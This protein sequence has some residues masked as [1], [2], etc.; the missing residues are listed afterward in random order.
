MTTTVYVNFHYI[1][2]ENGKN[3]FTSVDDGNGNSN[4]TGRTIAEQ[5]ISDANYTLG[6]L[7][8]NI[9]HK[10]NSDANGFVPD[11]KYRIELYY[12]ESDQDQGVHYISNQTLYNKER[13]STDVMPGALKNTFSIYGNK[14]I[15]IFMF[16]HAPNTNCNVWGE[17]NNIDALNLWCL[18]YYYINNNQVQNDYYKILN[19]EI[20]HTIGL[21]QEANS[22]NC[23]AYDIDKDEEASIGNN[24]MR[25]NDGDKSALTPKQFNLIQNLLGTREFTNSDVNCNTNSSPIIIPTGQEIVWDFPSRIN[26]E[27]IIEPLATLII[28]C[29][30]FTNSRILVQRSGKLIVEGATISSLCP[31]YSFWPGI[32]VEGSPKQHSQV[33]VNSQLTNTDPGVVLLNNAVIDNAVVGVTTKSDEHPWERDYWGGII[34]ASTTTFSNNRKGVE[35]YPYRNENAS[36]FYECEFSSSK[37]YA[38]ISMWDV[39]GVKIEDTDFDDMG[40]GITLYNPNSGNQPSTITGDLGIITVDASPT[41]FNNCTFKNLTHAID[42]KSSFDLSGFSRGGLSIGLKGNDPQ[43]PNPPNLFDNN[44]NHVFALGLIG[45][46]I[47]NNSFKNSSEAIY[48][49]GKSK[50]NINRN[51]LSGFTQGIM[52]VRIGEL[53]NLIELNKFV[54]TK[55]ASNGIIPYSTN[56]NLNISQNCFSVKQDDWSVTAIGLKHQGTNSK[57]AINLFTHN[58]LASRDIYAKAPRFDYWVP[59]PALIP[60][61]N[62]KLIPLCAINDHASSCSITSVHSNRKSINAFSP[63]IEINCILDQAGFPN[64]QF[65]E[66]QFDSL[67]YVYWKS[68]ASELH[69]IIDGGNTDNIIALLTNNP[70]SIT[71]IQLLESISP[72]LSFMVLESLISSSMDSSSKFQILAMNA[73]IPIEF[74]SILL[75]EF[76]GQEVDNLLSDYYHGFPALSDTMMAAYHEAKYNQ[77]D[78][79]LYLLKQ[80]LLLEQYEEGSELILEQNN[81]ELDRLVFSVKMLAGD[82][83]GASS[84]LDSFDILD[85]SDLAWVNIARISLRLDTNNTEFILSQ[86]EDSLL[87]FVSLSTLPEA[88]KAS[89]LLYLLKEKLFDIESGLYDT[90]QSILILNKNLAKKSSVKE[91]L[92]LYPNP[93]TNDLQLIFTDTPTSKIHIEITNSQGQK[94]LLK[95]FKANSGIY[96]I[97]VADLNNGLYILTCFDFYSQHTSKVFVKY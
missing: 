65:E 66:L 38:G 49:N 63:N 21:I 68:K 59:D 79:C 41:I 32:Q 70:N 9:S 30:V 62:L 88:A 84:F 64:D 90:A 77:M 57:P 76:D 29:D 13:G 33:N 39:H 92:I 48:F 95:E 1:L 27:V 85:T 22:S 54:S 67:D 8:Q 96:S 83:S 52:S 37:G 93:V 31:K 47:F 7:E 24:I 6:N 34:Q 28:N 71:T 12:E 72:Y 97:N 40:P 4:V 94:V 25:N 42:A 50:Y 56:S 74:E 44:K 26:S 5:I 17:S 82:I 55:N 11:A 35:F 15:D 61:L 60:N 2:D 43:N 80:K 75:E 51:E 18:W 53:T 20:L 16:A 45:V 46:S 78:A 14:V 23:D 69:D 19:H 3:N 89:A 86:A 73:P 36:F 10:C 87:E 81:H 58:P 91:K